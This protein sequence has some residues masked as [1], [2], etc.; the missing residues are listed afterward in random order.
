MLNA[1]ERQAIAVLSDYIEKKHY[2]VQWRLAM[3]YS[4]IEF[5][6]SKH[7]RLIRAQSF[8]DPDYP[9]AINKALQDLYS[10]DINAFRAVLA[11]IFDAKVPENPAVIQA[12]QN[13][14]LVE[15]D[16]KD[17]LVS[18]HSPLIQGLSRSMEIDPIF[19]RRNFSIEDNM[20]FMLMPFRPNFERI[21]NDHIQPTLVSL[22]FRPMKANDIF[23]TGSIMEDIWEHINKARIVIADVTGRNPNVF[24]ELGVAHTIG[25]EVIIITQNEAD[26]PFDLRHLRFFVYSDDEKGWALL[27]TNLEKVVNTI[28]SK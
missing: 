3:D 27:K 19:N 28:L 20:V 24:Y 22:N 14:G 6:W 12:F 5:D 21:Y 8:T 18:I 1:K 25:K 7:P 26:V 11:Y 17:I 10:Q 9:A 4:G 16:K 13:L 2:Y 15:G 23:G